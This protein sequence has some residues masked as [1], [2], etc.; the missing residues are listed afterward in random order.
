MRV[1][2]VCDELL[3]NIISWPISFISQGSQEGRSFQDVCVHLNSEDEMTVLRRLAQS[4]PGLQI[5]RQEMKPL[6]PRYVPSL[7]D[8]EGFCLC[9]YTCVQFVHLLMKSN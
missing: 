7:S 9:V 6:K 1:L 5:Q 4:P 8:S 2:S 3:F